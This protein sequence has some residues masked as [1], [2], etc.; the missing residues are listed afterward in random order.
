MKILKIEQSMPLLKLYSK[1]GDIFLASFICNTIRNSIVTGCEIVINYYL[2]IYFDL[3]KFSDILFSFHDVYDLIYDIE[4]DSIYIG[5]IF[6]YILQKSEIKND[7]LLM[8]SQFI[9]C[10]KKLTNVSIEIINIIID[11]QLT[12]IENIEIKYLNTCIE[13]NEADLIDNL[14]KHNFSKNYLLKK[15]S[16]LSNNN[17]NNTDLWDS[18]GLVKTDNQIIKTMILNYLTGI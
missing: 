12:D 14:L 10:M 15:L 9:A 17:I 1:C 3:I 11:F 7:P 2:K 13:N 8:Q 16:Q 18:L 6:R 5:K 4:I